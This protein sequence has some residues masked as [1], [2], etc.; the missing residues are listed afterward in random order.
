MIWRK[1][2]LDAYKALEFLKRSGLVSGVGI[3]AKDW[4]IIELLANDIELDWAMFANSMTIFK[5]PPDLINFMKKISSQ[6]VGIIN[7]AIFNAGFLTG[8]EFYD[9]RIIRPDSSENRKI[10]QWRND[11][12]EICRKYDVR[13]AN[14]CVHFGM[15][16]PEVSAVS[17]NT[18]NPDRVRKNAEAVIA[19]VPA[20]FYEEM[21]KRGLIR[22]DYPYV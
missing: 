9:Y 20:A 8:G 4:H 11:F 17:L 16:P 1:D 12:F 18:S 7:S 3:G 2:I 22:A 6:G 21:K 13:P 14:A 10:F 5:H 19:D 15:S